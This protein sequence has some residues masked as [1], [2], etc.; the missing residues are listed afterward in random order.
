MRIEHS[1]TIFPTELSEWLGSVELNPQRLRYAIALQRIQV[2]QQRLGMANW[3]V[4]SRQLRQLIQLI[5]LLRT[6]ALVQSGRQG[7]LSGRRVRSNIR[8]R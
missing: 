6:I 4:R 1:L 8:R 2:A 3:Q 5:Q 7:L